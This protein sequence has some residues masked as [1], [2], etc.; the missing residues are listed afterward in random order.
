MYY[1]FIGNESE[2][3]MVWASTEEE[4]RGKLAKYDIPLEAMGLLINK[5]TGGEIRVPFPN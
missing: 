5:S 3:T 4:L 2:M 1:A